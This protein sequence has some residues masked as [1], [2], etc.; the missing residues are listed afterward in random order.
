MNDLINELQLKIEILE[1]EIS[2]KN[3][4][5]SILSHDSKEMFGNILWLIEAV[6]EKTISE[7]D[8]L[9]CCQGKI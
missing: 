8:F 6:K 7:E 3:G 4:L 9:S 1:N 5:I 2:F